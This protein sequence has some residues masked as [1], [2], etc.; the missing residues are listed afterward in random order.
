M[1]RT[2]FIL[3][4]TAL[5]LL[6]YGSIRLAEDS[7]A[8][9]A[10]VQAELETR[11]HKADTNQDGLLTRDEAKGVMPRLYSHF[12]EIDTTHKGSLSLDDIEVFLM[13]K[14]QERQKQVAQK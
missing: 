2:T 1:N 12:D 7:A 3:S 14:I 10:K 13:G 9:M 8:T 5:T 11:F 6:T 4:A